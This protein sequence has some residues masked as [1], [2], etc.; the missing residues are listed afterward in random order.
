LAA[1]LSLVV[2]VARASSP[3]VAVAWGRP[4]AVAAISS[5]SV[6]GAWWTRSA[7]VKVSGVSSPGPP[8]AA[9]SRTMAASTTLN[10]EHIGKRSSRRCPTTAPVPV[11]STATPR[12]LEPSSSAIAAASVDASAAVAAPA[13][14]D[15]ALGAA[16]VAAGVGL[17]LQPVSTQAPP[18]N[19]EW[20]K[21]RRSIRAQR[22]SPRRYSRP[23]AMANASR[24][25]C[26]QAFY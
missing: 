24:V 16:P 26:T 3:T 25:L 8:V 13:S 7:L 5:G 19:E 10:V 15:P 21:V 4:R 9:R 17:P 11:S 12:R 1:G 20:R 2:W 18:R 14:P 22:T 6:T 23:G